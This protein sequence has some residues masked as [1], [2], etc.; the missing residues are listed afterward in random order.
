LAPLAIG[1]RDRQAR[2]AAFYMPVGRIG[3][4]FMEVEKQAFDMTA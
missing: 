4:L 2:S 3:Q 1:G